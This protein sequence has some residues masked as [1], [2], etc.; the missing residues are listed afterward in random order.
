[1][2]KKHL[3]VERKKLCDLKHFKGINFP[4]FICLQFIIYWRRLPFIFEQLRKNADKDRVTER[5]KHKKTERQRDKKTKRQRHRER[6][7][8]RQKDRQRDRVTEHEKM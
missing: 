6:K 5:K 8:D 2:Y 1:M 4:I 3:F 7:R